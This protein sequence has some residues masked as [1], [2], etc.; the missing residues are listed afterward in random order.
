VK[1]EMFLY[2]EELQVVVG[3][4]NIVGE[5]SVKNSVLREHDK[6]IHFI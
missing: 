4:E 1:L 2:G 3:G 5:D 6:S